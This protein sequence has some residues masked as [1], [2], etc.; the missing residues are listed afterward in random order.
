MAVHPMPLQMLQV[1]FHMIYLCPWNNPPTWVSSL[2]GPW[3]MA[4]DGN[5]QTPRRAGLVPKPR[6][7]GERVL[8]G[9]SNRIGNICPNTQRQNLLLRSPRTDMICG[10]GTKVEFSSLKVAGECSVLKDYLS[11]A[12]VPASVDVIRWFS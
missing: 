11:R 12:T 9:S 5:T 1:C 2:Q 10:R 3:M 8:T 6:T 7:P 4:S